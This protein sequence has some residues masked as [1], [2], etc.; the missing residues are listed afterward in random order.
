[1]VGCPPEPE[2]WPPSP[3]KGAFWV[4][5]GL[6]VVVFVI[7]CSRAQPKASAAPNSA[8]ASGFFPLCAA[9]SP[10][11]VVNGGLSEPFNSG[12]GPSCPMQEAIAWGELVGE[13]AG[14]LP[15]R[16]F[17]VCEP[18]HQHAT[19]RTVHRRTD[20]PTTTSS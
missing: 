11:R 5:P 18:G 3:P 16:P 13:G 9:K 20:E 2:R 19:G 8:P 7:S 14:P 10:H 15:F 12:D 6:L 17:V 1:M 4:Q